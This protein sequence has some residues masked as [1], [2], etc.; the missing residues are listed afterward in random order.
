MLRLIAAMMAILLA[1]CGG[2]G[3]GSAGTFNTGVNVE[4]GGGTTTPPPTV[5]PSTYQMVKTNVNGL[6]HS[7]S[8]RYSTVE[9][10]Q[11]AV[12]GNDIRYDSQSNFT[13][14]TPAVFFQDSSLNFSAWDFPGGSSSGTAALQTGVTQLSGKF[15][16]T[17]ASSTEISPLVVLALPKS[18]SATPVLGAHLQKWD[19]VLSP[20]SDMASFIATYG[21][22]SMSLD[23][24]AQMA[25]VQMTRSTS[26]LSATS[27]ATGVALASGFNSGSYAST[28][29]NVLTFSNEAFE[30]TS[31]GIFRFLNDG[32]PW[33]IGDSA[34]M[35]M[36]GKATDAALGNSLTLYSKSYLGDESSLR[37]LGRFHAVQW[38]LSSTSTAFVTG[39]TLADIDVIRMGTI[40]FTGGTS[41]WS[42]FLDIPD[43][44][45]TYNRVAGL[46]GVWRFP[47]VDA[48]NQSPTQFRMFFASSLR[49]FFG[50]DLNAK[51]DQKISMI[52]GIREA[53]Q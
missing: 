16:A 26:A 49:F 43:N 21:M 37:D 31:Q 38:T 11:Q 13:G 5:T 45:Y 22:V 15:Y 28:L 7:L 35:F 32:W 29:T 41:V 27:S 40:N 42:G 2:G 9:S 23:G 1:G 39:T 44:N 8:V 30:I 53:S 20:V 50:V 25:E 6:F 17:A 18:S 52:I 46:Q 48:I 47:Q 19:K 10:S 34:S 36:T 12:F 24:T 33:F 4:T 14:S 51:D 3:G